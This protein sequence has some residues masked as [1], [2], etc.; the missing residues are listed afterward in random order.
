MNWVEAQAITALQALGARVITVNSNLSDT[1]NVPQLDEISSTTEAVVPVCAFRTG[2][3]TWRCG[4]NLC[5]TAE[6]GGGMAP[7]GGR[8]ILQYRISDTGVGLG[9]AVVDGID[10]LVK[11]T[12]FDV[13]TRVR[14]DGSAATP[15]T[16]CFIKSVQAL[17]Y[18]APPSE[19]E[20]TCTPAATPAAF[21][22]ATY[23]N[24]F[25]GVATGTSSS[26]R[27]G[28]Q[29]QFTVHAENDGC[30]FPAAEAQLFT[31]FID[32][33]DVTTAQVLDTQEATII[34]PP[35]IL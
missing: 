8:C 29:L 7:V 24:G 27:P 11:Y 35:R 15:D 1:S 2:A 4:T 9:V 23:D 33:V 14:D 17:L 20:S 19:P 18:V 6:Y 32:V 3:T 21:L 5:C 25:A 31:A 22:G 10:A 13:Y 34:V 30:S 26:T 28:I 12:T 16:S